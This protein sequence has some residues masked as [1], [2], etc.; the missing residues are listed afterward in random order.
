MSRWLWVVVLCVACEGKKAAPV[1]ETPV[2]SAPGVRAQPPFDVP[3]PSDAIVAIGRGVSHACVVRASGAVDCWGQPIR[4]RCKGCFTDAAPDPKVRR[5]PGVT[6]A[7]A[8]GADGRCVLRKTREIACLDETEVKF[9]AVPGIA[10]ATAVAGSQPP[11]AI[12]GSGDIVCA[13]YEKPGT[14]ETV[15]NVHDAT[16]IFVADF[17]MCALRKGG[18][19]WCGMPGRKLD[20]IAGLDHVTEMAGDGAIYQL[21]MCASIEKR[22][23]HC[24]EL[25]RYDTWHLSEG[26]KDD[27]PLLT[28]PI[29]GGTQI[30]VW[31]EGPWLQ[32]YV[33]EVVA[34]GK[35]K[36]FEL[37]RAVEDVPLVADAKL[38]ARGCVVR[39]QGSVA[40]WGQNDGGVLA[41]PTTIGQVRLPPSPV[42]GLADVTS[43]ALGDMHAK[44]MTRD[45]T[46]WEWG[47]ADEDYKRHSVPHRY[48]V[49]GG[50]GNFVEIAAVDG[51]LC[52]RHQ[53]GETWCEQRNPYDH[54]VM[55]LAAP[56]DVVGLSWGSDSDRHLVGDYL[57][58]VRTR[59][60]LATCG[61]D[62]IAG[63]QNVDEIAV[64]YDYACARHAGSI[65]CWTVDVVKRS[66]GQA[67]A[68]PGIAGATTLAGGPDQAC[69]IHGKGKVTC[70]HVGEQG[71]ED[72][73]QV[74]DGNAMAIAI[75]AGTWS[76]LAFS[77]DNDAAPA[78]ERLAC[79]ILA[80]R[81]V[82]CWG[83][84]LYGELGDGSM[85]ESA[86][87]IGIRL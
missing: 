86:Q 55:T 81:T 64:G 80:D 76:R 46:I 14:V 52:A 12:V 10:N 65:S 25:L 28:T 21:R 4:K 60:R 79:A 15:P 54:S 87:P 62:Q 6:D 78:A 67:F 37:G 40:C 83:A 11:C 58:C 47:R 85:I 9:V 19:V 30:A 50:P 61:G 53:N 74:L 68:I 82:T 16:A 23:V 48:E 24:Y 57:Y 18:T 1:A 59:D 22:G 42:V 3:A 36:R 41:Q 49:I 26:D 7:I 73:K 32:N 20:R 5:V 33:A 72:V 17:A 75:G 71:V 63:V 69:A 31:R 51:A 27:Q 39:A 70:W 29:E 84:N 43:L 13:S 34:G 8:I 56:K 35:V 38:H 45:G 2:A 66:H 44:A 77:R